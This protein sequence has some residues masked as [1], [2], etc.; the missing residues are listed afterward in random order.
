MTVQREDRLK[1]TRRELW[2]TSLF[3]T[4][5][6]IAAVGGGL[7]LLILQ[8]GGEG[9]GW[10]LPFLFLIF[11]VLFGYQG[12]GALRDLQGGT[13]ML[14]GVITRHWRRF[15]LGTRSNYLRIDRDKIIRVD[16]VQ[17]LTVNQGD[18]V[19]IEYY[20]SSMIAVIVEKKEPP[21]G[22]GPPDEPD[23][24]APHEPDPLLIERD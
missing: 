17:H 4:P 19:E 23:G 6:C 5:L 12:I 1:Q 22:Y 3:W 11:G 8:L 15:D 10:V 16:R 24:P 18:Y 14:A 20:P 7:Y 13:A 21:E 2:R 9:Y